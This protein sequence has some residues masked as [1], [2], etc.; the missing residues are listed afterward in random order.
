MS[1]LVLFNGFTGVEL[2]VST[3][4][5]THISLFYPKRIKF[6]SVDARYASYCQRSSPNVRKPIDQNQTICLLSNLIPLLIQR[7][8]VFE[9]SRFDEIQRGS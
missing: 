3:D 6:T 2:N 1:E 5:L 8:I 7:K 9:T 4:L